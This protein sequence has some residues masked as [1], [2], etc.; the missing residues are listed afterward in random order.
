MGMLGRG[1]VSP[2]LGLDMVKQAKEEPKDFLSKYGWMK[3]ANRDKE[4]PT[5]LV[6]LRTHVCKLVLSGVVPETPLDSLFTPAEE[7]PKICF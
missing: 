2:P 4:L 3:E 5:K 6:T 1:R 7:E